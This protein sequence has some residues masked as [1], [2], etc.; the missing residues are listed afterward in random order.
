M[1]LL[2]TKSATK[3]KEWLEKKITKTERENAENR[4][5]YYNKLTDDFFPFLAIN[6]INDLKKPKS[7]KTYYHDTYEYARFFAENLPINFSF[8]D[9]IDIPERPAILK[10]RPIYGVNKNS[11]L[12]NLDKIRHF[13][14]VKNDKPF[15]EKKDMMIGRGAVF[16]QH[17]YDFFEK[18]FN[19]P[20]CDLGQVNKKGGNPIWI[21]PKISIKNHLDFKFILSLEGNDVATNLKWIMSSNSIAVMPKPKYETWFMEGVLEGGVHFIEIQSDYSDLEE[22]LSFY[23]GNPEKCLNIIKNAHQHCEQFFNKHVEDYCSLRV[24]EKYLKCK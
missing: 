6:K 9:V 7:P 15:I 12:L 18:Y 20:L 23:I 14:W 16:Q 8:G 1:Y 11:V 3:R 4:V 5:L 22:Q 24:F 13:V 21:K 2:P 17:R 10:S 19:H